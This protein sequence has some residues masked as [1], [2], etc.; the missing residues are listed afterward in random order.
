[1][2]GPVPDM[3]GITPAAK[4]SPI[5]TRINERHLMRWQS[6]TDCRQAKKKCSQVQGLE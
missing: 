3:V 6:L 1:M 2:I 5:K 4:I